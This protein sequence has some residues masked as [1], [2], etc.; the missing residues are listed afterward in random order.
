MKALKLMVAAFAFVGATAQAATNQEIINH[1]SYNVILATYNDLAAQ[2][3]NLKTAVDA[4]AANPTQ[5]TLNTAQAAWRATRVPWESSEAFLFGPVDSLGID[6]MLD[7][8]PLNKLDLDAVL[9]SNRA[10]TTDFVRAL[11]T[12]L[13]GFHTIEYLL[14]GDGVSSNTKPVGAL[15]PKQFEYLKATSTLLAEH[16]ATLAYTWSTNHDPENPSAPG[17]VKVISQPGFDNQ[18][19]T[20]D[21]AVM[22][23]FVQGMMGIVDE[24]ANGKMSDPLGADIGSAN[25]ALVE[26]PFAWNSLNDF[27]NN[28]RSV[29]SIYTGHYRTSKGPGVKALVE[30]VDAAL[31]ARVEQD[32]LNCMQ[33]IQAIRPANGGDFGQAIFTPDGRARTQQAIDALNALHG[34]LESEVLPTLDM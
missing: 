22:E 3:A 10:I 9:K 18:F 14:F 27:T 16:A 5:E 26:S 31:A 33:L 21:R 29:Y 17:Y 30:R 2:T 25:M 12:N 7:T 32:I 20:S 24:V 15:T 28:I 8:W 6:P 19:Y 13:Q 1:V 11:G 34:V 23:E 4:L